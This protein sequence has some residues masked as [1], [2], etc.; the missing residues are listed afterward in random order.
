[1]V[2]VVVHLFAAGLRF[3]HGIPRSNWLSIAGGISV[4]YVF[5][6]LLPELAKSQEEFTE[7][8]PGVLPFVEHHVYLVAL[9]GL[10]LFYGVE[11]AAQNSRRRRRDERPEDSTSP[12]VF[13]LSMAS[14]AVY[15]ALIGY[16]ILHREESGVSSLALFV[17]AM[18]VHFLV[19]DY[20]L[21]EHHKRAY[22]RLGRWILAAAL[23]AGWLV[24]VGTEISPAAIAILLAFVGGGIILNVLKEELPKERQSRFWAFAAGVAG[25]ALVLELI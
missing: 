7:T 8:S 18:A 11:R 5:V 16:L 2:L 20:G 22:G 13:G 3:L 24:G 15:N 12:S 23:L 21:R 4:A 19:T 14:F 17:V 10:A 25:Y 1:M 9:L 6:H